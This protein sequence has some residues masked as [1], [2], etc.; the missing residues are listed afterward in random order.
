MDAEMIAML[1]TMFVR[2]GLPAGAIEVNVN[3]LG[4]P[5]ERE[6][7]REK[8]VGY[9]SQHRDR[10]DDDSLRR[11]ETN[12]LRIL[13]SKNADVIAVAAGAPKLIDELNE[14][15]RARFTRVRELL[16]A[17]GVKHEVDPKLVRGLDYYTGDDLRDQDQRRRARLAEHGR[18]RRALR[19]S[20]RVAGRPGDAR[21]RL[22]AGHRT[23]PAGDP[24]RRRELRARAGRVLRADGRGGAGITRCRSSTSCAARG[25]AS[26]S[27]TARQTK[28][29]R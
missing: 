1:V 7:Y 17:L 15:S 14:G 10:L 24:R 23:R 9:F 21:H 19:P 12:P 28:S 2:F 5:E 25:S 4:E 20:G 6:A 16:T 11:L 27:N 26:R 22:R 3:S 13:D 18:G 29:A 8:L